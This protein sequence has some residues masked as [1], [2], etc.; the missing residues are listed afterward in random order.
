[1]Y[2]WVEF[3]NEGIIPIKW[4][5]LNEDGTLVDFAYINNIEEFKKAKERLK[6]HISRLQNE[7]IFFLANF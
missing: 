4:Y 3:L 6:D 2:I 5:T 1:M 7:D